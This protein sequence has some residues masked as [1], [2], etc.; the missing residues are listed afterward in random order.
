MTKQE[1][2]AL[3]QQHTEACGNM[4]HP[5]AEVAAVLS[6]RLALALRWAL[7]EIKREREACA[8]D[9]DAR[10]T[11]ERVCADRWIES[12]AT[13]RNVGRQAIERADQHR[14]AAA[15]LTETAGRIRGRATR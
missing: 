12:V 10:A 1:C 4:E 14:Y 11:S 15:V 7:D 13:G 3:L 2:E 5:L 8:K 9:V 6:P